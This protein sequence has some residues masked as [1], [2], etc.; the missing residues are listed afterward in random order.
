MVSSKTTA[1]NGT[2]SSTW[3]VR[4]ADGSGVSGTTG[5]DTIT[6][7]DLT[8]E[9]RKFGLVSKQA[10]G[11]S[12]DPFLDGLFGLAFPQLSAFSNTSTQTI[13]QDLYDMGKIKE[14]IVGIW[15]GRTNADKGVG[16]VVSF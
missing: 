13:V 9:N 15:L 12:R 7:G 10:N 14:P 2:D 1:E 8:I 3:Q 4:Y 16:E 5:F 6:V 11:F